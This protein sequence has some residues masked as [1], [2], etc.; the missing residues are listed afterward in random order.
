MEKQLQY[1]SGKSQYP[2][3]VLQTDLQCQ[4][5]DSGTDTAVYQT[6]EYHPLHETEYLKSLV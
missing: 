1:R 3:V 2:S 5:P 4:A 6:D